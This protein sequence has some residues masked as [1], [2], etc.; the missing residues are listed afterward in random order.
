MRLHLWKGAL[1]LAMGFAL[2]RIG[3]ADY[4]EVNAMFR[5]SDFR[6]LLSFMGGVGLAA[7][8]VLLLR[9]KRG[10]PRAFNPG[11][12]PGG[13]LFGLGWAL[14]G[15]C[16]WIALVQLGSGQIASLAT[17]AGIA[18]G[19]WIYQPVHARFFRWDTGICGL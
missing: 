5:F 15:A 16:P 10:V 2:M 12:I 9:V 1:G 6:L 19:T 18:L 4:R 8:A 7:L 14:S 11:V 13:M 17:I 3:F